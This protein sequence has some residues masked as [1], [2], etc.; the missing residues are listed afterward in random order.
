[1]LIPVRVV[2]RECTLDLGADLR[3]DLEQLEVPQPARTQQD[4]R[5]G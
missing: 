4:Y 1:V 5:L 2:V 3:L